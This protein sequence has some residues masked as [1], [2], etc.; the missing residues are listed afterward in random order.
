VMV[1]VCGC[2]RQV[3]LFAKVGYCP[4]YRTLFVRV[5]LVDVVQN[6][7]VRPVEEQYCYYYI[8]IKTCNNII[9]SQTRMAYFRR[10]SRVGRPKFGRYSP[11]F[12]RCFRLYL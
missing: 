12:G 1:D 4:F 3:S 10:L 6:F 8:I 5:V 2:R 9:V 11:K 7:T